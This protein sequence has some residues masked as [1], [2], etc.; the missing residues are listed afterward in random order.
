MGLCLSRVFA[1]IPDSVTRKGYEEGPLTC[2][3]SFGALVSSLVVYDLILWSLFD[4]EGCCKSKRDPLLSHIRFERCLNFLREAGMKK[5]LIKKSHLPSFLLPCGVLKLFWSVAFATIVTWMFFSLCLGRD[6]LCGKPVAVISYMVTNEK[7]GVREGW[8][9]SLRALKYIVL[10]LSGKSSLAWL[11]QQYVKLSIYWLQ[12]GCL[13][14][15]IYSCIFQQRQGGE[16][17]RN[18]ATHRAQRQRSPCE[19]FGHLVGIQVSTREPSELQMLQD[20]GGSNNLSQ[21][22]LHHQALQRNLQQQHQQRPQV[23]GSSLQESAGHHQ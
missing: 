4:Q 7:R 5:D 16:G 9:L 3:F 14:C 8:Y 12:N 6:A 21:A 2:W 17:F 19:G 20:Q 13:R 22:F 23:G 10:K 1:K 11:S 18:G 15:G